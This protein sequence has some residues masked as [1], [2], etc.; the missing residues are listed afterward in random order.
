[1]FDKMGLQVSVASVLTGRSASEL[2]PME[3]V[4]VSSKSAEYC[5]ALLQ[6]LRL[7]ARFQPCCR[8]GS[9]AEPGASAAPLGEPRAPSVP[10]LGKLGLAPSPLGGASGCSWLGSRGSRWRK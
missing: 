7:S 10:A 3:E 6:T 5:E 9:Q 8:E 1:M 2:L 4:L